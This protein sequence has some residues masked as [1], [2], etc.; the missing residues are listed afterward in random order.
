MCHRH[1]FLRV[2]PHRS[3]V[4]DAA[5]EQSAQA[6][7]RLLAGP[8]SHRTTSRTKWNYYLDHKNRWSSAATRRARFPTGSPNRLG[9][10]PRNGLRPACGAFS[11]LPVAQHEV[12]DCRQGGTVAITYRFTAAPW[13]MGR[14]SGDSPD[15]LEAV[16]KTMAKSWGARE[17][18]PSAGSNPPRKKRVR[19]CAEPKP[20]ED[21]GRSTPALTSNPIMS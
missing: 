11:A 4:R 5:R 9:R 3:G 8:L 18:R 13:E 6:A 19:V 16:I 15:S 2:L 1:E 10:L 12:G 17:I 14:F 7:N 20:S 21:H